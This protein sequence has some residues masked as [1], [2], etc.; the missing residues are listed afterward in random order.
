[1]STEKLIIEERSR[2]IGQFMVGRLLPFAKKRMV[3][4]FIFIDHMGPA[5][6]G[7]GK[8]A[9]VDQH[10][11]IG[12]ATLTYL[13]EGEIN[14]SDSIGTKQTI[15]PGEVNLMVAG[16]GVTHT[17]RTPD[18]LRE[19]GTFKMHG[20]QI[21][22]ALPKEFEDMEPEFHHAKSEEIPAW[23]TDDAKFQLIAGE[24]FDKKSPVPSFSHQFMVE[25]IAKKNFHFNPK[26]GMDGELGLVI[27]KG[28]LESDGEY[29]GKGNML[30][31]NNES[32]CDILIQE[33]SHILI[34]GGTPLPEKRFIHW[35]FVHSSKERIDEAV[36]K[37]KNKQFPT[38][39]GD[40]TYVPIP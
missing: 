6:L 34:F 24:A 32:D 14:H 5:I 20:Y 8:Y 19:E 31:S 37:W 25:I 18:H 3:G 26:E 7:N 17:E 29:I 28:G 23:E 1:M 38:V 30:V 12:L 4:P 33:D 36:E 13:I 40:D 9:D 27:V 22:I 35:N 16:S 10:P 11:H 15:R 39:E 2:D 21:W